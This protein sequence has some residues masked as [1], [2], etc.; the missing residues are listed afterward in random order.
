ML[1]FRGP[2]LHFLSSV[3]PAVHSS[4]LPICT[5]A[6]WEAVGVIH[7]GQVCFIGAAVPYNV[8]LAITSQNIDLPQLLYE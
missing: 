5:I 8:M 1:R 2:T 3:A 6:L 7:F 4:L